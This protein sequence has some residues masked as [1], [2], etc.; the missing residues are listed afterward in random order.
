L[1]DPRQHGGIE[2]DRRLSPGKMAEGFIL[3]PLRPLL[4]AAA[5]AGAQVCQ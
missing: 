4:L 3:R 2:R 5:Q 1:P